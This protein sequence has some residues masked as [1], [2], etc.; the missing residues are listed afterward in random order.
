[1]GNILNKPNGANFLKADIHLHTPFD[2]RFV[3]RSDF[4][5]DEK[6]KAFIRLY[7][8]KVIEKDLRLIAI[9]EHNDVSWIPYFQEV[10]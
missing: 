7:L 9:T 2:S 4:E 6:K 5:N 1:M 10:K 8:D 3:E